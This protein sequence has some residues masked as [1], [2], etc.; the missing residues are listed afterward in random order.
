[1]KRHITN[2]AKLAFAVAVVLV[3]IV[4]ID[5]TFLW[6]ATTVQHHAH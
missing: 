5:F 3:C 6:I 1:M 2:S 4:G